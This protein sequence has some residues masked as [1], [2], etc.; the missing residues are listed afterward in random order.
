MVIIVNQ[1]VPAAL[2]TTRRPK[3]QLPSFHPGEE[4]Q[5]DSTFHEDLVC[6]EISSATTLIIIMTAEALST[7]EFA[8]QQKLEAFH[9][10]QLSHS[11]AIVIIIIVAEHLL[12]THH[13]RRDVMLAD[14]HHQ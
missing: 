14:C 12:M 1:A 5:K 10:H 7:T 4:L 2:T 11:Y 9:P 8:P 3:V 6:V 13:R